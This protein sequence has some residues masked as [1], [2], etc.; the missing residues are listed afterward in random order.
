MKTRPAVLFDIDGTLAD[1]GHRLHLLDLGR[2]GG[3]DWDAFFDAMVDD[4]PM[5]KVIWLARALCLADNPD[6]PDVLFVTGRL[7]THRVHTVEWLARHVAPSL[8]HDWYNTRL[9]MRGKGDRRPDHV[10]KRS[11]LRNILE[12]GYEPVL[13]VENSETVAEMFREAGV[14]VLLVEGN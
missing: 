6:G 3:K 11:M 10:L 13:A 14:R 8:S 7:D 4:T 2:A 1:V 9:Y 12:T 5:A